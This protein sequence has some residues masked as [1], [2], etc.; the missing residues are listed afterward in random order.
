ML[1]YNIWRYLD[2]IAQLGIGDDQGDQADDHTT[3]LQ[4]IMNNTIRIVRLSC[5][6]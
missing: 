3:G 5:C 1:A 4:G 6:L 2:M